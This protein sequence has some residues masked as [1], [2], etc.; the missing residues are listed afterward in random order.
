MTTVALLLFFHINTQE[1]QLEW[2]E[3]HFN[4]SLT[5]T[6]ANKKST[7]QKITFDAAIHEVSDCW[8][9]CYSPSKKN[10]LFVVFHNFYRLVS[11]GSSAFWWH[12]GRL[13]LLWVLLVRFEHSF[14]APS[15]I[16]HCVGLVLTQDD[17]R[18]CRLKHSMCNL[19]VS[20]EYG[21]INMYHSR[22]SPHHSAFL[23]A[24]YTA[25]LCVLL[26]KKTHIVAKQFS[27]RP[28]M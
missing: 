12:C 22:W 19:H 27:T 16:F 23:F 13:A 15:H 9:R 25:L 11:H 21:S 1:C 24:L 7:N 14:I 4:G 2:M 26:K 6:E 18:W 17:H 3:R 20:I 8:T 5:K 10:K 28:N